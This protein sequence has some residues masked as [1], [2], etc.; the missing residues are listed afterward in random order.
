MALSEY[1]F[2]VYAVDKDQVT[3]YNYYIIFSNIYIYIYM[4]VYVCVYYI[5]SSIYIYVC[6]CVCVCVDCKSIWF[7]LSHFVG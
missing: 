3:M 6:V 2:L 1:K 5:F 4:C 7:S